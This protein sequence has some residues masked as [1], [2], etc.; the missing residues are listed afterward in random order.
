MTEGQWILSMFREARVSAWHQSIKG[1]M[2][3][4]HDRLQLTVYQ[5]H[6]SRYSWCI[7]GPAKKTVRFSQESWATEEEAMEAVEAEVSSR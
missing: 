1:N 3:R 4:R 5:R 6:D 7:A 2:T